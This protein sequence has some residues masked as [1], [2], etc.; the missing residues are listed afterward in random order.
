MRKIARGKIILEFEIQAIKLACKRGIS[1]APVETA[2]II[3]A[4]RLAAE[5][6][7]SWIRAIL[8]EGVHVEMRA[9]IEPKLEIPTVAL[10][11]G[12]ALGDDT[13]RMSGTT[14]GAKQ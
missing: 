8:A 10:D 5:R 1:P 4:Q 13:K 9:S 2:A 14:T 11:L 7:K 12:S 6:R 3:A